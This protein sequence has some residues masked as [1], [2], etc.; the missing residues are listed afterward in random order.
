MCE[1]I[2]FLIVAAEILINL[3]WWIIVLGVVLY[4]LVEFSVINSYNPFV[5]SL[6]RF[7]HVLT[8]PLYRW[9]RRLLPNIS[10]VD[11]APFG[12]IILVILVRLFLIMVLQPNLLRVTGC[13][14]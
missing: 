14:G 6:R 12:A 2:R 10:G 13:G 4:Y 11:I 1:L 9:L 8:E 3:Y 5:Q 7:L